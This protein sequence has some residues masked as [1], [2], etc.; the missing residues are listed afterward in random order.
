MAET[1]TLKAER[2]S[3]R[4]KGAARQARMRGQIPAVIY[5]RGREPVALTLVLHEFQRALAGHSAGSTVIDLSIAGEPVKTLIREIQ[6]HPYKPRILHIDF[7]EIHA[8]QQLT[9]NVPVRL[10]GSPEG[11]KNAGGVLD[12]V[13]REVE[14]EV[15]PRNIPDHIDLDV[16]PLEI[17]QSMHVSDLEVPNAKV[18]TDQAKTICAVVPPRVELEVTAEVPEELEEAE[19]ELIRKQKEDEAEETESSEE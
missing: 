9:V 3:D 11:V 16:S 5:G 13:L 7:M 17:N 6:R 8:G 18:L 15:L 19:P 4:G 12:Q 10:V 14:I 1:I 2:R